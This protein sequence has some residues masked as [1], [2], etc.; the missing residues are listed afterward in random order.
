MRCSQIWINLEREHKQEKKD[1]PHKR[2]T[3]I[4]RFQ[5]KQG[6]HLSQPGLYYSKEHSQQ[7]R[8]EQS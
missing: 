1:S 4:R 2:E 3:K 5:T 6:K 7:M 8:P